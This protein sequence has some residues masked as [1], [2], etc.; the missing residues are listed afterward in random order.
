MLCVVT[1]THTPTYNSL[2]RPLS[3]SPSLSLLSATLS[4]FTTSSGGIIDDCIITRAGETSFFVVSNAGR[5]DVD[6]NH[7]Q[8]IIIS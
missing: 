8:V 5:A 6:L 1:H 2:S 4:M 3:L 7:I